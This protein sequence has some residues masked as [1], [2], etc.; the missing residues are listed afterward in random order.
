MSDLSHHI[1]NLIKNRT[2]IRKFKS[3]PLS[4]KH[5]NQ[6]TEASFSAPTTQFRQAGSIIE[7]TDPKLKKALAQIS[8]QSYVAENGLLLVFIADEYRNISIAQKEKQEHFM[9]QKP[10]SLINAIVDTSLMAQN[11]NLAAESLEIGSVYL[12]SILNDAQKVIDL[13]HLP[14]YTFPLFAMAFGYPDDNPDIK[15]K[16]NHSTRLFQDKYDQSHTESSEF[17]TYN[18]LVSDYYTNRDSHN[19]DDSFMTQIAQ[20]G[21]LIQGKRLDIAKILNDQG[22]DWQ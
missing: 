3:I 11:A 13:L 6:I 22:F 20:G 5:K 4:E 14:K 7:I 9:Y 19:R 16:L 15:P 8:G 10:I 12:G 1:L 21:H 2:S 17:N 18:Q